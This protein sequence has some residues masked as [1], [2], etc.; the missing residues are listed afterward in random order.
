MP[1]S[2]QPNAPPPLQIP[3]SR[4]RRQFA[5]RLAQRK[6]QL[7]TTREAEEDPDDPSAPKTQEQEEREGHQRFARLFSGIDDSSDDESLNSI[8][9]GDEDDS[10]LGR[11]EVEGMEIERR[12]PEKSGEAGEEGEGKGSRI[13]VV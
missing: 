12:S 13:V 11:T 2:L 4:A 8:D 7:E 3:P 10:M 1:F 5:M 6:A 9:A